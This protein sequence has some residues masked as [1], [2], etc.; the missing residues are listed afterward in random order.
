M[1]ESKH[2][3]LMISVFLPMRKGSVRVANKNIREFGS[4]KLGLTELKLL[5][6]L[7]VERVKEIVISTDSVEI[8]EYAESLTDRRIRFLD[9][10]LELFGNC[11]TDE[12]ISYVVNNLDFDHLLWTHVTSPFFD[13]DSYNALIDKYSEILSHGIYDSIA[14]VDRHQT[15]MFDSL[16]APMFDRSV[17]RWP[18]TQTL[19]PYYSINSAAFLAGRDVC[20][21]RDDRI[22]DRPY[23]YESSLLESIDIDTSEQFDFGS[24]LASFLKV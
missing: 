14:T 13:N 22:G 8:K 17:K 11:D 18:R 20:R 4:Y 10:P 6:L 24:T 15:F 23:F 5:Q 9:R 1:I 19:N 16:G 3:Q 21:R 2:E 12:L 7:K